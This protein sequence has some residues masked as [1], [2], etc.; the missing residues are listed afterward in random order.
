MQQI[1]IQTKLTR[2]RNTI[3]Q[4]NSEQ[5]NKRKQTKMRAFPAMKN[6]AGAEL[7]LVFLSLMTGHGPAL[8]YVHAR[9]AL[10]WDA[11]HS[12]LFSGPARVRPSGPEPC[13]R[14]HPRLSAPTGPDRALGHQGIESA[15]GRTQLRGDWRSSIPRPRAA[16]RPSIG[17][18]EL[19]CFP[20]GKD[21][22]WAVA[23]GP[24]VTGPAR[25]P[26][27]SSKEFTGPTHGPQVDWHTGRQFGGSRAVSHISQPECNV[28]YLVLASP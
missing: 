22:P 28:A 20:F 11:P 14:P 16:G 17:W 2:G 13:V 6:V 1:N 8:Q 19:T 24:S 27:P 10:K 15:I 23:H 5:H 9:G 18:P 7:R 25:R 12:P 26:R 21:F 3:I 4:D